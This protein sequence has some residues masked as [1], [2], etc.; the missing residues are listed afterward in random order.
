MVALLCSDVSV[1]RRLK[2]WQSLCLVLFW[3]SRSRLGMKY[4]RLGLGYLGL[5]LEL[6]GLRSISED[7]TLLGVVLNCI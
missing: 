4:E 5:G 1:S 2:T 7:G 6:A 3:R